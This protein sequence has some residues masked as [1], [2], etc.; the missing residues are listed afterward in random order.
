MCSFFDVQW[1]IVSITPPRPWLDCSGC[2]TSRPFH[3][4]GRVRLNANGKRLDA[5]LIYKCMVCDQT[6]NRPLFER[7]SVG[8][9]EPAILAALQ[10]NDTDWVRHQA[11]DL[12]ELRRRSNRVDVSDDVVLHKTPFAEVADTVAN[13]RIAMSVPFITGLRL[14]RLLAAELGLSRSR[15]LTLHKSGT[16]SVAPDNASALRRAVRDGCQVTIA[17]E[18]VR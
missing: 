5:W 7:R 12:S 4:S 11:F 15:L 8:S 9:I 13:L 6:W 1:T 2:R 14:D 3:C 10:A 17:W 18:N 16:L